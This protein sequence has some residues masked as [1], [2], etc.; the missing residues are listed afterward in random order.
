MAAEYGLYPTYKEQFHAVFTEHS[1]MPEF[2]SLMVRMKVVDANGE[3][4][5]DEDQW[6]ATSTPYLSF[7]VYRM[8]PSTTQTDIYN[9]FA[10]EKR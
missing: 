9:A 3:S 5:I 7:I 1:N 6:D 8:V 2:K 10:F 4:T